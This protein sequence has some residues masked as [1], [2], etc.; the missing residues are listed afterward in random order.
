MSP[1]ETAALT[2]ATLS[3]I[4]RAA[5]SAAHSSLTLS[6]DT[7]AYTAGDVLADTQEVPNVVPTSGGAMRLNSIVLLDKDDNAA[8]QIDLVFLRSSVS[9][10]TENAAPSI[11]DTNAAEV[12]G[13]VAV[14]AANFIDVG[15]AKL[16]TVTGINL[17]VQPTTGTS[18][19]V[20]AIARGTPTQSASGIVLNLGFTRP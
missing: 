19:Y 14:P 9:V 16:A 1:Q 11:T 3:E 10:G 18:I 7:S 17:L 5:V 13:I 2:L 20:A 12:L 6:L 8:A 15:G 4:L